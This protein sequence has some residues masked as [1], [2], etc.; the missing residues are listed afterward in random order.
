LLPAAGLLDVCEQLRGPFDPYRKQLPLVQYPESK[1]NGRESCVLEGG[2][3]KKGGE[4]MSGLESF[5]EISKA[6][7]I[8]AIPVVLAI[9]GWVLQRQ[10][11]QQS[12]R[13]EYVALALSILRE[14]DAEKVAP[15]LRAWAVDLLNLNSDLKFDEQ[16]TKRLK[17]GETRLP[18]NFVGPS[19]TS[20]RERE[21]AAFQRFLIDTG[22]SVATGRIGY[23][24]W[25][26]DSIDYEGVKY[27]ALYDPETS[28][29][30]IA[31]KYADDPDVAFHELMRRVLHRPNDAQSFALDALNSGLAVYFPCSFGG[32]AIYAATTDLKIDLQQPRRLDV[33]VPRDGYASYDVGSTNWGA[34]FWALRDRI[35]AS[36][37]GV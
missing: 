13:K 18:S 25:P 19:L 14:P 16:T 33:P 36:S 6:L 35:G 27:T 20:S 12:L 26:G 5:V 1:P 37:E 4:R 7:S 30:R 29:I 8:A 21:L 3:A 10:V 32:R 31:R 9:G 22:F 2:E 24:I 23:D 28:T 11:Q 15:E 17:S 34:A